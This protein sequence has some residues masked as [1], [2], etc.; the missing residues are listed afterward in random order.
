MYNI[1]QFTASVDDYR[2]DGIE[3]NQVTKKAADVIRYEVTLYSNR[4]VSDSVDIMYPS[5]TVFYQ[6]SGAD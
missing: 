3:Y 1:W 6:P 4:Q 5:R 2:L